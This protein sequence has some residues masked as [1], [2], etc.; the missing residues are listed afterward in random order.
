M[1]KSLLFLLLSVIFVHSSMNSQTTLESIKNNTNLDTLMKFV[2]ELSGVV[3][4]VVDGQTYT[5][6]SRHK[7]YPGNDIAMNYIRQK[8]QSYGYNT[9]I[10]TFSTTGK[11]VLGTKTGTLYP[12]KKY[13]ICAHFDA[14]PSGPVAPGAD[15]NA[16][17]TAAV[18]EAAR[19]LANYQFPFTVVFALWDEEEQGLIG[20]TYY[21]TQ[22]VN[23]QDSILGVINMDM[24]AWDSNNDGKVKVHTKNIAQ[25][26]ALSNK[27]IE[28][29]T[30]LNIGLDPII[31]DPGITAS[32]HAPFWARNYSAI[33]L[34]EEDVADFNSYYHTVNDVWTHFNQPYFLKS[35]QLA[36]TTFANFALNYNLTIAHTPQPSINHNGDIVV[37]A[38]LMTGLPLGTGISSPKLYYRINHGG[39]YSQFVSVNGNPLSSPEAIYNFT[40]PGQ[41]LGTAVEYYIA[42]QDSE[43]N[44][45]VTMPPG[46]SGI[47]PPGSVPPPTAYRFYVANIEMV[48]A[49]S[50]DNTANWITTGTWGTTTSKFV[51]PPS[52][53]TE[54][55]SGNY[56]N[57]LN[58]TM[59]LNGDIQLQSVLGA[60]LTFN[61]QWDIETDYDY[62]QILISTNNG[63][64][65]IP[66]A[67]Q[68]TN[69]GTGT[70]QPAGQPLYDGLQGTWITENIDISAYSGQ[71]IK[72]RF[73][74]RSD[75]SLQKD[76]WYIDNLKISAY[77]IVPVELLSFTA[78]ST[79]T[80][81]NLSWSTGSELNNKGF[82]VE[83]SNDNK[84]FYTIGFVE[85]RGTTTGVSAYNFLDESPVQGISFYR[86]KQIDFDGTFK[87]YES[88]QTDFKPNFTFELNQNYPNPFNPST[89]INYSIEEEGITIIEIYDVLGSKIYS[90]VNE[91]Q[92]P[93]KYSFRFDASNLP[94]GTYIYRLY[95]NGN[96][97]VKKM[98]LL[99]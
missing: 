59:T 17:G 4:V 68:Y 2:K 65:W 73:L 16:S 11:N 56:A 38:N 5:I 22:A 1:K 8:L 58:I 14:M 40:I 62:G 79:E 3:P 76:G 29:N 67:G 37:T 10:Q 15:D 63:T 32:D 24:I 66:L 46:G 21:A 51:S 47:N 18:L 20:A 52:S 90:E 57:N 26:Y 55:P 93:G 42:A 19:I 83:R 72:L 43:G 48:M 13:I 31:K 91:N 96:T 89:V 95:N 49:D 9:A 28:L 78:T 71:S 35:A 30:A 84:A 39:G 50:A 64:S 36:I 87:H 97:A 41:L 7:N 6:A 53:F 94:A 99:K 86:L 69:P 98:M 44:L 85:G 80:D 82:E 92:K 88:V 74:F 12:N 77:S 70:F 75:G 60:V 81:I 45:V 33:L 27:M 25:S 23:N 54:S 34:I 61:S